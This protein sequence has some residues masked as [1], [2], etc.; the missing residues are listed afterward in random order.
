MAKADDSPTRGRPKTLVRQDV[1][2]TALMCYWGES[3][4]VPISEICKKAGAS[5][6]GLYR[7]FGSDDGLK[8]AVLDAYSQIAMARRYK[9]IDSDQSFNMTLDALINHTVQDRTKLGVPKGCL[10]Y[11]MRAQRN[12]FGPLTQKKIGQLRTSSLKKYRQ[13]IDRAKSSRQF[14]PDIPTDIAALY[15]DAQIGCAMRLQKEGVIN[16]KIEVT[17]RTAFS[18]LR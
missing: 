15:L 3:T 13:W 14:K 10:L 6:P 9:I 16:K 2:Q 18:A 4:D 17:L 5:K 8:A 12:E 11:T 7:E 1:L